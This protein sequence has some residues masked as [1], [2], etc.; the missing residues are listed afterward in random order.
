MF[1]WFVT[2]IVL[3][4]FASAFLCAVGQEWVDLRE[5]IRYRNKLSLS[6]RD[7]IFCDVIFLHLVTKFGINLLECRFLE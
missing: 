3:S 4:T 6:V 7:V 1:I 2:E 5:H